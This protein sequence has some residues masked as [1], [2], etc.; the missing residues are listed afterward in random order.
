MLV[1][2]V[3][4][5]DFGRIFANS[6]LIEAAARNAAEIAANEYVANPPGS[7]SAPATGGSGYYADL[8]L[9]AAR[10]VCA[11]TH[12]LPNSQY[13]TAT[14]DC[15]GMPLI[16]VCVHDGVDPDCGSEAFS[17]SVPGDC[18]EM[19]TAMPN[20]QGSSTERWVE[21]RVCY[22]FTSL[23]DVP[24]VS[25]GQFWLQRTRSFV[26]PCYFVIGADPC[27]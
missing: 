22:R 14:T 15:P 10:A 11:E 19:T 4:F 26:I 18:G 7:L 2:F 17:A 13:D 27:G 9:L 20:S 16:K 21:V 12:K 23:I 6:I 5:A 8:H 1:L 3:G 24:L 25:F